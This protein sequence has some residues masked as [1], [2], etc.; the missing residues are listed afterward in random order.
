VARRR[1]GAKVLKFPRRRT[2]RLLF[3]A[4]RVSFSVLTPVSPALASR[5]AEFLF[6]T[7]MR[8]RRLKKESA[9][10]ARGRFEPIPFG[11]A[12]LASWTWGE[13]P[14][15]VLVHGWTGHAGRL[16]AHVPALVEAG[17]SVLAFDAPGHG[18]SPGF[19]SSLPQFAEALRAVERER[20]PLHGLV[21]HSIGASAAALA[22]ADG[23]S[24]ERAVFLAPATDPEH[25]SVRF[26]RTL[27]ITE[28]VRESMKLRIERRYGVPWT[29]FRII[30]PAA[31]MR[32]SLLVFHDR[33]DTKV[34]FSEGAS[35]AAA[36]PGA[37]LIQTRGLGHHKILREPEVVFRAAQF[38]AGRSFA[39]PA[40]DPARRS[41]ES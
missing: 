39:F 41:Q 11:G 4:L 21:A 35:I 27:R 29:S 23:L 16:T 22:M 10:L 19:H 18:I 25:Y 12:P 9:W 36:W 17:F 34:P 15:V 33:G 40:A 38:L 13:G 2:E 1:S 3:R 31:A 32:A 30:E 8:Q 7:P 6:R 37:Q 20:G 26:A 14:L 28:P 24:V 5:W